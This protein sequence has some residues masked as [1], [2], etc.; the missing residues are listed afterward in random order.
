VGYAMTLFK[1]LQHKVFACTIP[2]MPC[3]YWNDGN[4][5]V[6][7]DGDCRCGKKFMLAEKEVIE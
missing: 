3:T 5:I 7:E 6:G 2:E 1:E 4:H